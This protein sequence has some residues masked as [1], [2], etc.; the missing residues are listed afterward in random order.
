MEITLLKI[1]G[2]FICSSNNF[3]DA[4]GIF[5]SGWEKADFDKAN[6]SFNPGSACHSYNHK[7][8]VLRGMHYQ[9]SPYPQSKLV[10]CVSGKVFDV[11]IDL[12]PHSPTYLL[13]DSAELSAGS[14]KSVF[15]PAGCAHGFVTLEENSTVFYLIEG[16]Y[17]P[18]VAG[19]VRWNDSRI[20][21]NWPIADPI[22]SER[23]KNAPDYIP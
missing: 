19:T 13:W 14:G 20:S 18:S 6:I 9:S 17:N 4:R 12:R 15:I 21:I 5:E 10:S 11:L 3:Q 2:S 8:G 1:H 22:L 16:D 23:D 7:K